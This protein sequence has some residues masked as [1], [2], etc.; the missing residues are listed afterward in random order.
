M[1]SRRKLIKVLACFTSINVSGWF[2]GRRSGCE[3]PGKVRPHTIQ[4]C[5]GPLIGSCAK[6]GLDIKVEAGPLVGGCSIVVR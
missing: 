6:D 4:T 3:P 2:G 1:L 5:K